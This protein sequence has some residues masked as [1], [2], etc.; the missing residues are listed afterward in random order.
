MIKSYSPT[1]NKHL[2]NEINSLK[3]K[4]SIELCNS[5]FDINIGDNDNIIC[6]NYKNKKAVNILLNSLK[7]NYLNN[8]RDLILPNQIYSNCWFNTMFTSFFF[9]DKGRKFF[10]YFRYL[11]ITGKKIKDNKLIDIDNEEIKKL[12]FILNIYIEASL[13]QKK[14]NTYKIKKRIKKTRKRILYNKIHNLLKI[15]NLQTNFFIKEMYNLIKNNNKNISLPNI[16]DAGNPIEYYKTIINFLDDSNIYIK[17]YYIEGKINIENNFK[18]LNENPHIVII[19]DFESGTI[20]KQEYKINDSIYKLDSIIL[21]NKDHFDKNKSSHF[22]NVLTINNKEY[23]FD[24]SSLKKI[25]RFNWKSKINENIDWN[26]IDNKKY[27]SLFYNF[28]KGYKIMFY[29]R[30]N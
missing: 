30:I 21:T 9:S 23:K 11:M 12:L 18:K 7:N 17:E 13:N 22:V 4:K 29:Y 6:V 2:Y 20:F 15:K 26:F 8:T 3:Y 1:I 24:G 16:K 28:T 14:N 25:S 5:I 19:N 27:E 10:K